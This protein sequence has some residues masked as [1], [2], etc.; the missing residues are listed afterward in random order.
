MD[1]AHVPG[2]ELMEHAAEA[3]AHGTDALL[4]SAPV[5]DGPPT[6]QV[7]CG[8]GNNGG[9]GYAVARI[10]HE[11]GRTVSIVRG[12][13]PRRDSDAWAN[14]DRALALGIP[15]AAPSDALSKPTVAVDA[16]L[17]TGFQ[18][19]AP[20]GTNIRRLIDHVVRARAEGALVLAVDLPSGLD[21]DCGAPRDESCCVIA[22]VT[23]TMVL[24]KAGFASPRA[25]QWI[26][27]VTVAGI[28]P[29]GRE[30]PD[31]QAWARILAADDA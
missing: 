23:V 30:G 6:V 7:V 12:E 8:T 18:A 24:P 20:L 21:A 26:G 14:A 1:D 31:E 17:G 29:T 19:N 10:L 22:D 25:Q 5:P 4:L 11:R 3:I 28:L 13:P 2:I 27:R 15:M 9:D 16:I